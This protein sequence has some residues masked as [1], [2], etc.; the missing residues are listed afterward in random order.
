MGLFETSTLKDYCKLFH[1]NKVHKVGK[2][3]N[4]DLIRSIKP[5]DLRGLHGQIVKHVEKK[6]EQNNLDPLRYMKSGISQ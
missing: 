5:E 4:N 2:K 6:E 3:S 1:V